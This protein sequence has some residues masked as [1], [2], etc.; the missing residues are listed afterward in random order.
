MFKPCFKSR[1]R[2]PYESRLEILREL[3]YDC[4]RVDL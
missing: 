3:D 2:L 4:D 1:E